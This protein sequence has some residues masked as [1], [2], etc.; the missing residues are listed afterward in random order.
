VL[1]SNARVRRCSRGC[2]APR[3]SA[4]TRCARRRDGRSH[5][6]E[7]RSAIARYACG[8]RAEAEE[9]RAQQ[10]KVLFFGPV[11]PPE[12]L[13]GSGPAQLALQVPIAPTSGSV[14]LCQEM[15]LPLY[16]NANLEEVAAHLTA[17]S[18]KERGADPEWAARA[19]FDMLNALRTEREQRERKARFK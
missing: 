14:P 19:Y 2:G 8:R 12:Q 16:D 4:V 3:C 9:R 18:I 11:C 15:T 13:R 5:L 1:Y 17:A 7:R 6:I 10:G